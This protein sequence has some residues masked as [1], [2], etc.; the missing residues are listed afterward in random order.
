[1]SSA[2][3]LVVHWFKTS[4]LV[5]ELFHLGKIFF[6]KSMITWEINSGYGTSCAW[7]DQKVVGG[8]CRKRCKN[9]ARDALTEI[10]GHS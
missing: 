5:V 7:G 4:G 3:L 8:V 1:M 9:G 2:N 6:T 10:A